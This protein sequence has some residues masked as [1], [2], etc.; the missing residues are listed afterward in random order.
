M[1]IE[2]LCRNHP[3]GKQWVDG[4]ASA[5]QHH[6]KIKRAFNWISTQE[7]KKRDRQAG[8]IGVDRGGFISGSDFD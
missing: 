8:K 7:V 6:R 1:S 4:K 5:C 2:H 3:E